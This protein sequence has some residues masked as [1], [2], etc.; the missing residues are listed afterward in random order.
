M[1][2]EE[3]F[4]KFKEGTLHSGSKH[5]PLVH[6]EKQ[7]VAI[8]LS[9]DHKKHREKNTDRH[10]HMN[11]DGSI[12]KSHHDACVTAHSQMQESTKGMEHMMKNG[13]MDHMDNDGDENY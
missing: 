13:L 10:A 8:A 4:H 5:G 2:K 11:T 12:A 6:S 3:I 9:Y 7:A 1:P